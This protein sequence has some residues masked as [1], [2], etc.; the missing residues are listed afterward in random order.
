[1]PELTPAQRTMR[2]RLAAHTLHA[3]GKTNTKAATAG[4]MAR[5]EREVDPE[6]QLDPEERRRRADSAMKAYM[7]GL[8]L[9]A[10]QAKGAKRGGG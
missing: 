2:A 7:A 10:S 3:Q 1:V 4:F 6:G 9:R 5:F 8:S